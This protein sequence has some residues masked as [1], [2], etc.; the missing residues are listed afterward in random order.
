MKSHIHI[1]LE[2]YSN[3]INESK[4]QDF[5]LS[6]DKKIFA[7]K[8]FI[9]IGKGTSRVVYFI[10]DAQKVLKVAKNTKGVRQ[11]LKEA[12]ITNSKKYDDIIAKVLNYDKKGEFIVQQKA[13]KISAS[14]FEKLTGIDFLG[15]LYYLRFDKKWTGK[16]HEFYYKVNKLIKDFDLDRFD[17]SDIT[18]WGEIEGR[19]V[20]I[21]YG[22]TLS[23]ARKLYKV[24]Y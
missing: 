21:D 2:E 12:E 1:S 22:L 11:N 13:N 7:K 9:L 20:L 23:D 4:F 16:N 17:I 5:E 8:H 24:A 3:S 10:Y 6:Q 15:F 19:V 14:T 18:S